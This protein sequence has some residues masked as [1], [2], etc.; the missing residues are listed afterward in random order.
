M[1]LILIQCKDSTSEQEKME[2]FA[3]NYTAAWNSKD[4]QK[5]ASFYAEDGVL[6]VNGG[7]PAIGRQQLAKTAESYMTA[8]PDMELVMDSLVIDS[9]TYRYYWTFKGTNTGPG[10]NGNRVNFSGFEEWNLNEDGLVQ[11]S[12]GTYDLDDY[13]RQV[14]GE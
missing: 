6:I 1:A 3:Q 8:F 7:T 14:R 5:M 11:R 9:D 12:I 13:L 2:E 4:P 10:G